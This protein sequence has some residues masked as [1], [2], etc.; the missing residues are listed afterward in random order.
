MCNNDFKVKKN[1]HCFYI[2]KG[3][4]IEINY[5]I[6]CLICDKTLNIA[7]IGYELDI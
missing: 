1:R 7:Q 4:N 5:G 3:T 2:P 6:A